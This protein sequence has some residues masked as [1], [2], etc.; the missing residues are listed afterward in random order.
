SERVCRSPR[1]RGRS[2]GHRD[3]SSPVERHNVCFV[4]DFGETRRGRKGNS[5]GRASRPAPTPSGDRSSHAQTSWLA[6]S[7][8]GTSPTTTWA[9]KGCTTWVS[10]RAHCSSNN[11]VQDADRARCY[12]C[13]G[14]KR[15]GGFGHHQEL[16][17]HGERHR[18]SRRKRG[19]IG[20]RQEQIVDE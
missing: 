10:S 1:K 7:A 13:D 14:R 15:D 18:V 9:V 6:R 5:A 8:C 16:G 17:P 11:L 3:F 20:E 19:C 2:P 12:Q 4:S